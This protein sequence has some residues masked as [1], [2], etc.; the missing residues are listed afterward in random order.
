[1]EISPLSLYCIG[2]LENIKYL[3]LVSGALIGIVIPLFL[4]GNSNREELDDKQH[5]KAIAWYFIRGIMLIIFSSLI[6]SVDIMAKIFSSM[7]R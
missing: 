5:M 7:P 6:P 3:L 2:I 4:I 1:M